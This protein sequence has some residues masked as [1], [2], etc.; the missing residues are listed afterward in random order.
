MG[1]RF[2]NIVYLSDV[3]EISEE[4]RNK[5]RDC[6]YLII[7]MLRVSPKHP[8]HFVLEESIAEAKLM[9]A[10]HTLFVGSNH[11]V[12]HYEMNQQLSALKDSEGLDIQ[13]A[14]DGQMINIQ[15]P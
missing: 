5:C 10:K 12:D 4:V 13:M 2:E 14:F 1:F 11:T 8:S 6:E 9:N 15:A 3:S 7:D